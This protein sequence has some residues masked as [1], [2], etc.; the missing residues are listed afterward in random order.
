MA[1]SYGE[2]AELWYTHGGETKAL[3]GWAQWM[4]GIGRL[5]AQPTGSRQRCL[6][7]VA[8]PCR[9]YAAVMAAIG[10]V[11]SMQE[12]SVKLI[13]SSDAA[14]LAAHFESL[15]RL[16]P[17]A[18]VT[19]AGE[20]RRVARVVGVEHFDGEQHVVVEQDPNTRRAC[21]RKFPERAAHLLIPRGLGLRA[22][23]VGA[24]ALL[25]QEITCGDVVTSDGRPL[26]EIL[27]VRRFLGS[28]PK[29]IRCG[30]AGAG[31]ELHS[32]LTDAQPAVV[33]F[34]GAQGF[35][36]WKEAWRSSAW[37]VVLDRTST[38][39]EEGVALVEEEFF[40]RIDDADL[41]N[42]LDVPPGIEVM[43][44]RRRAS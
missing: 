30:L 42:G 40:Q 17:G 21:M 38:Q 14:A 13:D 39:F 11:R 8:V 33:V 2:P 35:R 7:V 23:I 4:I 43:G 34:D 12:P 18:T 3:P 41:V 15:C 16:G 22:L 32:E 28:R 20:V 5:A 10:C 25:E 24:L 26:Q 6:I 19:V 31:A 29:D 44:F 36:R 1:T 37:V 9:A 27:R